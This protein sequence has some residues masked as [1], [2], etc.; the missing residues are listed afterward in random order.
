MIY[1]QKQPNYN[2]A[3]RFVRGEVRSVA[4][5]IFIFFYIIP[6]LQKIQQKYML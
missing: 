5:A 3:P 4:C 1:F 6:P 2:K